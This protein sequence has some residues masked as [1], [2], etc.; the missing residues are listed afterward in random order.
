MNQECPCGEP[1]YS[2]ISAEIEKLEQ[3][4]SELLPA[5]SR[6]LLERLTSASIRRENVLAEDEFVEGFCTAAEMALEIYKH[7]HS[8]QN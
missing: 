8:P 7:T 2:E 6:N 3:R 5:E 4:L 1:E